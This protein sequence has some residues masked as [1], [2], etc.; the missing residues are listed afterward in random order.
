MRAVLAALAALLPVLLAPFPVF[1][2]ARLT[3][4]LRPAVAVTGFFVPPADFAFVAVAL[5]APA[6]FVVESPVVCPH[7]GCRTSRTESRLATHRN[8]C[9][10]TRFVVAKTLML[11]L[12]A[13]FF[14][15]QQFGTIRVTPKWTFTEQTAW[16]GN[17]F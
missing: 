7:N 8:T 16:S 15:V 14:L 3:G 13:A 6:G 9:R 12:Y 17:P 11:P 1:F 4:L 2:P 10:K 5:E